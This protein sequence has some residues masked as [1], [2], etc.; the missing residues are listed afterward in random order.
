MYRKTTMRSTRTSLS[1]TGLHDTPLT[2]SRSTPT[3]RGRARGLSSPTPL[4]PP[5]NTRADPDT[6]GR[7]SPPSESRFSARPAG[8]IT[9]CCAIYDRLGPHQ[10]RSPTEHGTRAHMGP[11][12][13][14]PD[15][16]AEATP[17][18][19][20]TAVRESR[21]ARSIAWRRRPRAHRPPRRPGERVAEGH[22]R[23]PD[24]S[25]PAP[26]PSGPGDPSPVVLRGGG[27]VGAWRWA[28]A[29]CGSGGWGGGV[30]GAGASPPE[31]SAC[32]GEVG[33][34]ACR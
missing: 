18:L 32:G 13:T 10:H 5:T 21:G 3:L 34:W 4:R 28:G 14:P 24:G 33:A 8:E 26:R 19:T 27:G 12:A 11:A 15:R 17:S 6:C 22:A 7:W 23:L 31:G 25:S 1:H 2:D 9:P 16:V 30:R 20:G 29:G